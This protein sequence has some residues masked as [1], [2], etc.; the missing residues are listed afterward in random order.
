MASD[1]AKKDFT[2][3]AAKFGWAE[4]VTTWVLAEGALHARG[5]EDFELAIASESEVG[6][7]VDAMGIEDRK[8][9]QVSRVRQAWVELK[10]LKR[11]R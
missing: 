8:P 7:L 2:E 11:M 4:K 3:L 1:A 10:K 9:Q 5:L 6:A